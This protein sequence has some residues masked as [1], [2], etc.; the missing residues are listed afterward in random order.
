MQS[1]FGI[2]DDNG[3]A[4]VGPAGIADDDISLFGENV[5]DFTLT[6]IAPLQSYDT[7]VHS[8]NFPQ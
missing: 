3:V 2:T 7:S 1:E 8:I 6:F 4:G 5:N